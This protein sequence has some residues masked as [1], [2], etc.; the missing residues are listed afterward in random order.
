M[1]LRDSLVGEIRHA[2]RTL[3]RTPAFSIIALITLA[4]GLG[5]ATAIFTL[6]D[7]VVL[8]PLPYPNAERLV[9]LTSPVPRMKGQTRWGLARHEMFYFLE[10]GRTLE[11]LGVYQMSDV[12]VLGSGAGDR[13]ERVRWIR[14]SASLLHVLGFVPARGRLLTSDD[15]R[16]AAPSVVLLSHD[17]WLR[18]YGGDTS[19]IGR[20]LNVEG[21]PLTVVGILRP[22]AQLPDLKAEL[23]APAHVDS[24]TVWNNHTW[25]A[26]GRLAAGFT[27]RD[28]ERELAPLTARLPEAFPQVYNPTFVERT[29][30]RTEVVPLRDAVVGE[31]VTRALWTLFGAVALVLLIAAANVANLFLVRIDARRREVAV[32][33]ALGARATHLARHYLTESIL[34]TMTAAAFAVAL[35]AGLLRILIALAPSELPR[36]SD[37]HLSATGV[38]F[39]FCTALVTGL[40]F[41]LLPLLSAPSDLALLRQEARGLT[42]SR[43]RLVVRR[44]LVVSQMA[45]AVILLAAAG[46]M[47]QTFRNL[48][49]VHMGF[50][51]TGV[52]TMDIALPELRYSDDAERASTLYGQLAARLGALPGVT[53]VGFGDRLPLLSGDWCTG[54]TIEGP[55]SGQATGTCP[56]TALVSPGYFEA[57]GIRV[58]GRTLDWRGMD[59]HDG[60]MVVSKAF[61]QH[62]WPDERAIGKGLRFNGTQPPFYRVVGVA[63]DVKAST[64][65]GPPPEVVYFPMRPIPGAPLWGAP[66]QMTLTLRT[67]SADPIALTTTVTRMLAELEPQAAVANVQTMET[68]VA[69]AIARHSFTMTLLLIA[70]GVAIVLSAVG[71][72]GVMAYIV[73]QRRGEI[74]IRMALGARAAQMRLGVLRQSIALAIIG[75]SVGMGG[76]VATTRL[77]RTLLFGVQPTDLGTFTLV[78]VV[79]LTVVALASYLPAR[80]ASGVDPAQ[81]LRGE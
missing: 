22:G 51:P 33:T 25:S 13:S 30:F 50:N 28:A 16:N 48:R 60:A 26:I 59:A 10:R 21:L 32:R 23:W 79:L 14:T 54:V 74:G 56:P 6:L 72:Y 27:A 64:I 73:A 65:D 44:A 1:R 17:Y 5:A 55:T 34:L 57:M 45:L 53:H 78:P 38:V 35:A 69:R 63:E 71:I 52:L 15:N 46:L 31:L 42:S 8:R 37:V 24:T 41:G 19:M 66:T 40:V 18:R 36:L 67:S 61:A 76:A 4:L 9:E 29:G 75:I 43:Q 2:A 12:T 77:L 58:E 81:V 68:V 80:R 47:V 62:H 20:Q 3:R 11:N 49:T 39:A 7:A 70:G